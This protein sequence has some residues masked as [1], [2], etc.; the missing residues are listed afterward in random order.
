MSKQEQCLIFILKN[1]TRMEIG[2]KT[3]DGNLTLMGHLHAIQD[4]MKAENVPYHYDKF[5]I[6]TNEIAAVFISTFT[7][8][9]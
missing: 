6:D 9:E 5:S 7:P 1:G 2:D 4:R 3:L 8:S